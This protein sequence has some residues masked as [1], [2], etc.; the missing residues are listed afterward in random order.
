VTEQYAPDALS[1]L[2]TRELQE[3]LREARSLP[4]ASLLN[5][6]D[7]TI[8]YANRR[9]WR[10]SFWKGSFARDTL[11]GWEERIA[12]PI[13]TD[14]PSFAGG[15]FWK[16]F[17]EIRGDEATGHVVNYGVALLPGRPRVRQIR[18]PDNRRRYVRAGDDVL[19]L[20]YLNHPYRVVY[21]LIKVVD[22]NNC[23]GVMHI[24][25]FPA[26]FEFATF[27]M[28]RNNYP[29][30]KMAV[31]DHDAIM[32]GGRA[33]APT[34]AELAA[35]W[36]GYLVFLRQPELALHNQFNPPLLRFDFTASD[37]T[38]R[39]R[40]GP[41]TSHSSVRFEADCVRLTNSSSRDEIRMIAPDILIGRR[42]RNA[43]SDRSPSLRYVLTRRAG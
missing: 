20:T 16:R 43:G 13:R 35:S 23:V 5:R 39:V 32:D 21:D 26:G 25:R 3:L 6:G 31:P 7:V 9:V 27:V 28:A 34:P 29:F 11:L 14:K 42:T 4:L 38:A 15:R 17:D 24:G 36:V 22:A 1:T 37:G 10:D 18:Y 8:D 12:T 19:L 40:T 41:L 30:E 2:R 33:H